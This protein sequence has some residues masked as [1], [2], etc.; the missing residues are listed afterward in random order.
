[1]FPDGSA[2]FEAPADTPLF[3]DPLDAGGNRILMKWNYPNTAVAEGTYYPATQMTYIGGRGGENRSCYGCH[4]PQNE[5]V[6]NSSVLA[7]K[8]G[9]VRITREST[10]VQYRRNE[11]EAFRRQARLDEV[12]KYNSWLTSPSPVQRARA[13][14]MLMYIE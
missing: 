6:A 5:A 4:A 9:P 14:E 2:Y 7:V 1:L 3:L 10:D 13:C 12:G 11:P 8:Y